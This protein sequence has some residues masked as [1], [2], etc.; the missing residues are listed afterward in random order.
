M[1]RVLTRASDDS[2][3]DLAE[4]GIALS[5]VGTLV[6]A[7][8]LAISLEIDSMWDPVNSTLDVTTGN[9][10]HHRGGG[11]SGNGGATVP[12]FMREPRAVG[13]WIQ[14]LLLAL[15][16]AALASVLFGI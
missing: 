8:V 12:D 10:G 3:Q 15:L 2:G 5:V 13:E 16:L 6:V 1:L 4:Y 7:A 14:L 9:H 11:N